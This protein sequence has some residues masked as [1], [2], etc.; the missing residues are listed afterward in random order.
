MQP[1][2]FPYIGYWQLVGMADVFVLYDDVDY[3]KSGYINRNYILANNAKQ[4]FTLNVVGAS[5]NTPI[6]QIKVGDNARK[7]VKTIKQ[8]YSKAPYFEDV[9]G[10]IEDI[11]LNDE[12]NLAK[13]LEYSVRSISRY[14][15]SNTQILLSSEIAKDNTLKGQE[16]II[17][18]CR[19]LKAS[20]Y[21]NAIGGQ[22]L[23]SKEI[24]SDA[25]IQLNFLKTKPIEYKQFAD[26]FVPSLSIIDIMMFN[27][28]EEIVGFLDMYELI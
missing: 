1:Y 11:L 4:R 6:N 14:L 7:L 24:F 9:F 15:D 13:Y 20:Q 18:L 26:D 10:L 17:S 25:N 12:K 28:R 3:I 19:L 8:E 23:Y 22:S 16:K 5:S 21:I 2:L 27:S